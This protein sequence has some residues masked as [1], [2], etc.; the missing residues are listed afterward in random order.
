MCVHVL[1][2]NCILCGEIN[3]QFLLIKN[4]PIC[5][6]CEEQIVHLTLDDPAY[7]LYL[8]QLPRLWSEE[9]NADAFATKC[10]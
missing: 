5:Y 6:T 4:K 2:K 9:L 7:I 8:H 1:A 3:E 10:P